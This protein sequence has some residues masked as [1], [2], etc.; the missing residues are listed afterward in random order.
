MT[1]AKLA[2]LGQIGSVPLK[3]R[4]AVIAGDAR[5]SP[6]NPPAAAKTPQRVIPV[7]RLTI[8]VGESLA[9]QCLCR[10]NFKPTVVETDDP[11]MRVELP[12]IANA[13]A[14]SDL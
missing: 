11:L 4:R 5:E 2:E 10:K 9:D 14:G 6:L 3:G 7:F 8:V 12:R 13:A 1:T